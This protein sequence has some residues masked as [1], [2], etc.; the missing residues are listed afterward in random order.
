M[1]VMLLLWGG[2]L[3]RTERGRGCGV[4]LLGVIVEVD[5]VVE[6]ERLSNISIE[7]CL[8]GLWKDESWL[9]LL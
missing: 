9:F 5:A 8:F 6:K 7:K 1:V 3:W 4:A 2:P